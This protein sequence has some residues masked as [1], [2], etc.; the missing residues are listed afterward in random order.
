VF[1]LYDL[2]K[3]EGVH[4]FGLSVSADVSPGELIT[5]ILSDAAA[6][7]DAAS[8]HIDTVIKPVGEYYLSWME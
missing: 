1:Y 8:I 4:Q 5:S 6:A 7:M 2:G 3:V